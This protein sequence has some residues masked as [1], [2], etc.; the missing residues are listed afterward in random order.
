M[1]E[2]RNICVYCGSANGVNGLYQAAAERFGRALA[3]AGIR[4]VYG[5]GS[6]GLMGILARSVLAHGGQVTG[7]IPQFLRDREVMLAEVTD[8]AVTDDMHQRKRMMFER[9]DAF[10]ALPGGIGTLEEIVE[11]LTWAQLRRHR[12]PVLFANI[13]SFWEPLIALLHHM[14]AEGFLHKDFVAGGGKL[15]YEL[16]AE[17]DDILPALRRAAAAIP[18]EETMPATKVTKVM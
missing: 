9:A 15:A 3:E 16:V 10:V 2:I 1:A 12:K 5:G 13:A 4:L 17:V 18:P 7:I 8:L 14:S 11:V 6:V